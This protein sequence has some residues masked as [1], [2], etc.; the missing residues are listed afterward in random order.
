M[1]ARTTAGSEIQLEA[2]AVVDLESR[3]R[4]ALLL[5]GDAGYDEARSIWNAMIDRTPALIA[6]CLGTADVVA[7][8]KFARAHGL[9]LSVKSVANLALTQPPRVAA[10]HFSE[11]RTLAQGG[12]P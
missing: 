12:S 3:L 5:R 1:T 9:M 6:R 8:V 11:T 4:G 7:C 10:V 2:G